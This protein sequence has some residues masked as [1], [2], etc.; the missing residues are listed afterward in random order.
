MYF[1]FLNIKALA[2]NF[3]YQFQPSSLLSS[4]ELKNPPWFKFATA[5]AISILVLYI[6]YKAPPNQPALERL[7]SHLSFHI[8]AFIIQ[9]NPNPQLGFRFFI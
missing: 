9:Q 8:V 7:F 5:I 2:P 4:S 3:R 1:F 6:L